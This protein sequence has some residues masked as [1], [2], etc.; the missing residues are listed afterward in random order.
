MHSNPLVD[1]HVR[2]PVGRGPMCDRRTV[3]KLGSVVL[4]SAMAPEFALAMQEAGA[5][6][7]GGM[8]NSPRSVW[9]RRQGEKDLK[10][11]YWRDGALLPEAYRQACIFL[12]DVGFENAILRGDRRVLEAYRAARL[13]DR[14]QVAA[15]MSL[16][17]LDA[18]YAIGVWLDHFGISRPIIILSAYRHPFYN[19]NLVEGA[20]R[21]SK[22]TKGGAV[23]IRIDG[24]PTARIGQFGQWLGVGG[25][26]LYVSRGFIHI[27][28]GPQRTWAG[29]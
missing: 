3:L 14:I 11:V 6:A 18:L 22:H 1:P 5:P 9:L 7:V 19:A 4:A 28:D 24:V 15:P 26:G 29:R 13:P 12:R 21:D 27:D 16:R 10:V 23:D 17:V 8:W 25:I 20:A 2:R